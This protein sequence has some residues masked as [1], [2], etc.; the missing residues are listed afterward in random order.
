MFLLTGVLWLYSNVIEGAVPTINKL[1]DLNKR[2]YFV[3]NNST[4]TISELWEHS[5]QHG[6]N[7]TKEE[8]ISTSHAVAAYL[9]DRNF[10]KTVYIVGSI[11]I[12]KELEAVGIEHL[13]IGPDVLNK[14]LGQ[15]M[16]EDFKKEEN[17]KAVVV[18]FDEHFSFLKL[19]KAGS[20]LN[21]TDCLF[22]ATNTD[23]RFPCGALTIP[24][25][26]AIVRSVETCAERKAFII[27]KPHPRICDSLIK[28]GIIVAERTLMIGDR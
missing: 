1:K 17:V 19:L 9:K 20:Y 11:G 26:G 15:Y 13:P 24:G 7:I 18:G 4:K 6:F 21:D 28:E 23:E 12:A 22:I 10:N 25:T 5:T 3:T 27:G 16:S 2:V 8:I 14:T